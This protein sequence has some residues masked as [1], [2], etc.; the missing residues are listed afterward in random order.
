[1]FLGIALA[2]GPHQFPIIN[3]LSQVFHYSNMKLTYPLDREW[4][5]W[6]LS[7]EVH[8]VGRDRKNVCGEAY[9]RELVALL[10]RE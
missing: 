2:R 4:E 8:S 6:S 10:N 9:K 5:P 1:M 3:E 7:T